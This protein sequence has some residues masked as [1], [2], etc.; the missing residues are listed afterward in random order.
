MHFEEGKTYHIYNRSNE[1]LFHS[2]DN[3][4]YFLNKIKKLILPNAEILAWCLM[5]NHFHILLVANQ[6]SCNNIDE[7]HRVSTQML[8][9]NIGTLLSSYSRAINKAIGRRGNL[10]AHKTKAKCLN[11]APDN[12]Y[13]LDNCFHYIHQNPVLAGLCNSLDDWEFSSYLDYTGIRD[14]K[15]IHKELAM[16]MINIDEK[17]FHIQSSILLDEKLLQE[18]F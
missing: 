9:K 6:N 7:S 13:L 10:F 16:E 8:S 3:Y 1:K 11:D 2:R 5:P 4:L 12:D 17:D 18:I 14:G 15:L